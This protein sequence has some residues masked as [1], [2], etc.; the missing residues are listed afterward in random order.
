MKGVSSYQAQQVNGA[1]PALLVAMLIEKAIASLKEAIRA[2]EVKDVQARWT[3]NNRAGEII[4]HL[5]LT[6]DTDNGSDIAENLDRLY[7]FMMTHLMGVDMRNDPKPAQEVIELL[8][9]LLVSWR[10]LARRGERVPVN[11]H[12]ATLPAAA[13]APAPASAPVPDGGRLRLSA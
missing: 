2:I 9:P 1:S 8:E 4:N 13:M 5:W 10:E 7:Q 3:A 6:L 11:P 12:A